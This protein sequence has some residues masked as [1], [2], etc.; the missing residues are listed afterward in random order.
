MRAV[1]LQLPTT[2]APPAPPVPPRPYIEEAPYV[3]V[4]T[5]LASMD[6][7]PPDHPAA[8]LFRPPIASTQP[9]R[10]SADRSGT[11]A[12]LKVFAVAALLAVFAGA[13]L[14]FWMFGGQPATV[15]GE[16]GAATPSVASPVSVGSV[17]ATP[18]E[19][20]SAPALAVDPGSS[21]EGAASVQRAA[22]S[23]SAAAA[24]AR[25]LLSFEASLTVVSSVDAE[26][27]VQGVA[28]GRTNHP[29]RVRCGPRNV[30]LRAKDGK[31]L[32]AGKAT[33]LP[34]MQST[35]MELEPSP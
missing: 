27:V 13:G 11:R 5:R 19:G 16:G 30:R 22:P 23:A 1:P 3:E 21:A 32:T 20:P 8:A 26:V 35:T 12:S 4:P 25:P 9:L 15:P 24:E 28:A 29:L 31:W 7:W 6:D 2:Q 34:C 33:S 17:V 14:A 18:S 10:A